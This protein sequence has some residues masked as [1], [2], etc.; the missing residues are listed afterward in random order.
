MSEERNEKRLAGEQPKSKPRG[1]GNIQIMAETKTSM[2]NDEA[3]LIL[4]NDQDT[5]YKNFLEEQ[6][7]SSRP[8][9]SK[10]AKAVESNLPQA[11]PATSLL[12]EEKA[13]V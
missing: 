7:D 6:E 1:T 11:L 4:R 5:C 3:Y 2:R 13:T 10:P 8:A 12:S 9:R